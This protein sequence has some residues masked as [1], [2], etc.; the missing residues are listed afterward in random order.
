MSKDFVESM[1]TDSINLS[2]Q[3]ADYARTAEVQRAAEVRIDVLDS[4]NHILKVASAIL[5]N[6]N[7]IHV[8]CEL[9]NTLREHVGDIRKRMDI[10]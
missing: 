9:V 3:V 10:G 5:I 1:I 2:N 8:Q 6:R 4:L 7:D